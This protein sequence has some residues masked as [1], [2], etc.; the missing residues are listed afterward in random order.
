MCGVADRCGDVSS[1]TKTGRKNS[2]ELWICSQGNKYQSR[3]GSDITGQSLRHSARGLFD[4]FEL[5]LNKIEIFELVHTTAEMKLHDSSNGHAFKVYRE[6]GWETV[7][8]FYGWPDEKEM[9]N[10]QICHSWKNNIHISKA[11]TKDITY[12]ACQWCWKD[13][14]QQPNILYSGEISNNNGDL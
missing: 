14:R 8:I 12:Q 10:Y 9:F 13:I 7:I 2:N 6:R 5:L 3:H 4:S 11:H 1:Y